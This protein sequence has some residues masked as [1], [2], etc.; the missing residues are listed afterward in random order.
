MRYCFVDFDSSAPQIDTIDALSY[1][2]EYE[3][4]GHT[5]MIVPGTP[6]VLYV[7]GEPR[8]LDAQGDYCEVQIKL[9]DGVVTAFPP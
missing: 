8:D 7:D 5:I 1:D 9:E 2:F 6:D 3:A 4:A